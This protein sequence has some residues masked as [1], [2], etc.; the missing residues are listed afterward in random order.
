MRSGCRIGNWKL[1]NFSIITWWGKKGEELT[2]RIRSKAVGGDKQERRK[3][4]EDC[5]KVGPYQWCNRRAR[6][7]RKGRQRLDKCDDAVAEARYK[8]QRRNQGGSIRSDGRKGKRG[9]NGAIKKSHHVSDAIVEPD[10]K[11]KENEEKGDR[12]LV[13]HC[14]ARKPEN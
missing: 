8:V 7:R 14:K 10:D 2:I 3:Q 5:A 11:G 9:K 13:G 12:V 6:W 1:H 4:T